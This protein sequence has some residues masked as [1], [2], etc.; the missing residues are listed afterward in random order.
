MTWFGW[1]EMTVHLI[2]EKIGPVADL[3]VTDI[4]RKQGLADNDMVP[5]KYVKFLELLYQELPP[6]IDRGALCRELQRKML[7][8]YNGKH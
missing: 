8:S 4:L 1:Q 5:V 3:I 7:N 6:D 2:A